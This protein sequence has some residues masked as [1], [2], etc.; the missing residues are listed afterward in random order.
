MK[1]NNFFFNSPF[2]KDWV[3]YVFLF[4]LVANISNGI[5]SV[6]SSGG[7][8]TTSGGL[9]SGLIDGAFRVLFSWI[10]VPIINAIRNS[11]NK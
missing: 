4:F 8:A 1:K 10:P 9:I 6:S 7:L 2:Y 5:A 11:L 3:F